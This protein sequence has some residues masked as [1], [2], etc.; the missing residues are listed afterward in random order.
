MFSSELPLESKPFEFF[1]VVNR[2][3]R[4]ICAGA[5]T[6]ESLRRILAI[7]VAMNLE[8]GLSH[9]QLAL[10]GLTYRKAKHT[11]D[12]ARSSIDSFA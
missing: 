1:L 2:Q 6:P 3:R 9:Q 12:A 8:Y 7:V 5:G 11:A 10:I 4:S